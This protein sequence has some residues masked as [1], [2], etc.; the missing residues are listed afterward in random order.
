MLLEN[1]HI[2]RKHPLLCSSY[3]HSTPNL[4]YLSHRLSFTMSRFLRSPIFLIAIARVAFTSPVPAADLSL[5]LGVALPSAQVSS[6]LKQQSYNLCLLESSLNGNAGQACVPAG[7][8]GLPPLEAVVTVAGGSIAGTFVAAPLTAYAGL[9]VATAIPTT[10]AN[11]AAT[12]LAVGPLG[13]GT[14]GGN[15]QFPGFLQLIQFYSVVKTWI[16]L[17][18][19]I[20]N[21]PATAANSEQ[22]SRSNLA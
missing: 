3:S 19:R 12:T 2:N 20:P 10:D 17:C 13:Q 7:T 21:T 22:T 4:L 18:M 9:A 11:G 5:S 16:G 14:M 6:I 15:L 1:K 8:S